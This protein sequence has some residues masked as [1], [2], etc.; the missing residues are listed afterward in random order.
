MK[1][2]ILKNRPDVSIKDGKL[3]YTNL[4]IDCVEVDIDKLYKDYTAY[5]SGW[6][7]SNT[8]Q[9]YKSFSEYLQERIGK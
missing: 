2:W 7:S 3:S 5:I 8:S 1:I 6:C 9:T 4:P